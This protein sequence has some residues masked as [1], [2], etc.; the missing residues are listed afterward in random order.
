V[1]R[2]LLFRCAMGAF[3]QDVYMSQYITEARRYEQKIRKELNLIPIINVTAR[4][5]GESIVNLNP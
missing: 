4:S 1:I 3:I 5:G 2:K